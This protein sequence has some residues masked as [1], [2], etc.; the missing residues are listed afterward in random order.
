MNLSTFAKALAATEPKK[1]NVLLGNGFSRACRNDIFAYDALFDRADFSALSPYVRQAFDVLKTRD[2]EVV[3]RAL[4]SGSVLVGLYAS[5]A[6]VGPMMQKDA[7]DL[8]TLLAKTIA[9]NH[10]DRPS[11]ISAARYVACRRF[12]RNFSRIY[13]L[14]Y[15][16]LLYWALMQDELDDEPIACD[17]GFRQPEEGPTT[18]VTWDVQN[19]RKQ[20]IYY[21]HGALHIFDAG[22]EL[23][24]YTWSNTQIALVDQIREALADEKYPVFVAE[25]DWRGK[26]DRIQHSGFLNRA[27]RSFAEIGNALFI[28]GHSMAENDDHVLRLIERG[29]VTQLWIGVFGDSDSHWNRRIIERAKHMNVVR[30]SRKKGALMVEFYDAASAEVWGAAPS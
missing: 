23:Q 18:Y 10:P 17:D 22:H 4:R 13:T 8:R 7:D 21:I 25:G 19:T 29:N 20:N 28:F 3:M 9:G 6:G 16:L 15:D 24:K 14:N 2:F 26:L 27:Y 11:D 1:R 30:K 5:A 12:L